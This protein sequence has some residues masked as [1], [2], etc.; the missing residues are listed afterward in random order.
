MSTSSMR[1]SPQLVAAAPAVVLSAPGVAIADSPNT[2][3]GVTEYFIS[4]GDSLASGYQSDV[5]KDTHAA[6]TDQLYT[7]LKQ[8][9]PGLKHIRLGCDGETTAS[10]IEGG[11]CHY[12]NAKSQ[13]DAAVKAL[14]KHLGHVGYVTIDIG[15]NGILSCADDTTDA[16]GQ[17][18]VNRAGQAIPKNLAGITRALRQAGGPGIRY[19]GATYY[20]PFLAEWLRGTAGQ[21]TAGCSVSLT[22]AENT[23]ISQVYAA[24][25]FNVADVARAFSSDDV[26]PVTLP[27]YGEVSANVAPICRLTWACTMQDPHANPL[28]HKVIASAFAAVLP[29]SG[30]SRQPGHANSGE[31]RD[32]WANRPKRNGNLAETGW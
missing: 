16:I 14:A 11:T 2:G 19:A 10:L 13:L 23:A 1:R 6:Y 25:G 12:P 7:Q 8:R 3:K 28:G 27:G 9:Q 20:N 21:Q 4:L 18:C 24:A 31:T 17:N 22:K 30:T 5:D 15:A 32:T 26:T 29:Q